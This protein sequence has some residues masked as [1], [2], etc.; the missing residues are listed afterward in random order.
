M[1]ID[2][3]ITIINIAIIKAT[4]GQPKMATT[5]LPTDIIIPASKTPKVTAKILVLKSRF[6]KLAASVPVHAPVP[7]SGTPTNKK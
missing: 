6:K 4:P 2:A 1:I 7:G 5:L 3:T